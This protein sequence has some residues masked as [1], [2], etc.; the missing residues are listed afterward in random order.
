MHIRPLTLPRIP[1]KFILQRGAYGGPY[2][3]PS[4]V[5][6]LGICTPHFQSAKEKI[7]FHKRSRKLIICKNYQSRS[8]FCKNYQSRGAR[9][10][11]PCFAKISRAVMNHNLKQYG[12]PNGTQTLNPLAKNHEIGSRILPCCVVRFFGKLR[13]LAIYDEY[14]D[15][16]NENIKKNIKKYYSLKS[17]NPSKCSS[18]R[19][20]NP[21]PW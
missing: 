2:P 16:K 13:V 14:I 7:T 5:Q 17:N 4:R 19:V 20:P 10:S 12:F 11:A 21:E 8:F 3:R 9:V 18:K 1:G 15:T 6:G